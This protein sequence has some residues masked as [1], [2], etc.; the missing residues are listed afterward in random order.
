MARNVI[1][2]LKERGLLEAVTSPDVEKVA[3]G[4]TAVYAGFDP[5]SDSLQV[6]NLVAI[7]G[8]AHFQRSGHKVIAV[9]G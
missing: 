2:T 7:L 9:I 3:S 8:L 5:S 4:P 6:G 1:E